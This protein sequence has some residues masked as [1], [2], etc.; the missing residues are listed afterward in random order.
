MLYISSWRVLGILMVS[1]QV[2]DKVIAQLKIEGFRMG[3]EM[4]LDTDKSH[5]SL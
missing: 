5:I 2:N 1:L 4:I 3:V